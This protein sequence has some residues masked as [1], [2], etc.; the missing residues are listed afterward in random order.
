MVFKGLPVAHATTSRARL[1]LVSWTALTFRFLSSEDAI[2][3]KSRP[4]CASGFRNLADY[5]RVCIGYSS[6]STLDEAVV[7]WMKHICALIEELSAVRSRDHSRN[8]V[9][10]A[11]FCIHCIDTI[12]SE[13]RKML[14]QSITRERCS[15]FPTRMCGSRWNRPDDDSFVGPQSGLFRLD[16]L[17]HLV[18]GLS[19]QL[20]VPSH[21]R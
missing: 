21:N 8:I 1:T 11:Y 14:L 5:I 6:Y 3:E 10:R 12:E 13:E 16:L 19:S 7:L 2:C 17:L 18:A 4:T 15:T 20:L 9:A